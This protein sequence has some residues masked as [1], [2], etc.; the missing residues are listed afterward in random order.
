MTTDLACVTIYDSN[1]NTLATASPRVQRQRLGTW[2]SG[3]S[4]MTD[5]VRRILAASDWRKQAVRE[6]WIVVR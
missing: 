2:S 1:G 4:R 6:G 3:S 5:D